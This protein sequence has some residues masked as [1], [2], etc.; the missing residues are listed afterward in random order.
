MHTIVVGVDGSEPSMR[1]LRF[2]ARL[3]Q[4]LSDTR[5][6]VAHAR[7]VPALWAPRH[8]PE[9]EFSDV[10]DAA[11]RFVREAAEHELSQGD[12][13]W[14]IQSRDGEPSNVLRDIAHES[15]A[16]FVVV[17]RSGWSTVQELLLGSVSNRLVH[18]ADLNVLLV[19]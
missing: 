10:L 14:S 5:L 6:V 8:V 7:H 17:G 15:D 16:T 3:A 4:D 2:A 9:A 11:E 1:A 12:V 19:D 18:R 13:P